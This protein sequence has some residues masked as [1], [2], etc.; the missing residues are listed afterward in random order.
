MVSESEQTAASQWDSR[1]WRTRIEA[2]LDRTP[3]ELNLREV[4]KPA[5]VFV[6]I[7]ERSEPTLLL[8][9]RSDEMPTHAGQISFPGGRL[10]AGDENLVAT[11]LREL[12]E[13][14][15]IS[16]DMVTL[17]GFLRPYETVNSGFMILPVVGFV[18]EGFTLHVNPQEVAEVIEAPL[19]YLMD[20]KN[21]ARMSVER[22]G[23]M[24]EFH[25]IAFGRHTIWGATAE[26]IVNLAERLKA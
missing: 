1:P 23:V 19:E 7:I 11:A 10:H 14:I 15:G 18:R 24:R 5:A 20:P 17:G 12:K 6:P 16:R 26:M 22:Q 25:T 3:S 8:T 4:L 13:E 9:K 2:R 21:R